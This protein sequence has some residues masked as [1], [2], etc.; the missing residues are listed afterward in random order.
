MLEI[1]TS[2]EVSWYY[3]QKGAWN[4]YLSYR[5]ENRNLIHQYIAVG[6]VTGCKCHFLVWRWVV[7]YQEMRLK[8]GILGEY[9]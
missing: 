6:W 8:N 7:V 4:F 2:Y 5:G 1:I 3:D 9:Q